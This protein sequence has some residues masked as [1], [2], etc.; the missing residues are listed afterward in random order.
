MAGVN[1]VQMIPFIS[2]QTLGLIMENPCVCMCVGCTAVSSS[3]PHHGLY[4]TRLPCPWSSAGKN[5]GV[6]SDSLFQG[7]FPTQGL[8]P[9]LMRCRQILYGLSQ[10]SP[11]GASYGKPLWSVAITQTV[12]NVFLTYIFRFKYLNLQVKFLLQ[13][14]LPLR[15]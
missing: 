7:I 12:S 1:F 10:R 3:L 13:K 5:T 11:K 9:G 4:P 2:M 6:G 14:V 15:L 8:N